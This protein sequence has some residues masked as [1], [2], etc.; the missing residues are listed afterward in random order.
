MSGFEG[1]TFM[2]IVLAVDQTVKLPAVLQPGAVQQTVE[3]TT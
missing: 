2:G 1:Q 3:V